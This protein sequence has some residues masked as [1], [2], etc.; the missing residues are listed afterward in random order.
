MSDTIDVNYQIEAADAS[1]HFV[2]SLEESESRFNEFKKFVHSQ[3]IENEDY[4]VIPG[5]GGKPTLIKPGAEKL[6]NLFGLAISYERTEYTSQPEFVEFAYRCDL[7]SRR[8]GALVASCEA[9]ACSAEK[10]NWAKEPLKNKNTIAKICQKRALVGAALHA[11]RASG[12]FTQDVEDMD[13]ANFQPSKNNKPLTCA[14]CAAIIEGYTSKAGKV[15]TPEDIV[16]FSMKDYGKPLC[17][18]CG[19]KAKAKGKAE[20]AESEEHAP[21][22]PAEDYAE[23]EVV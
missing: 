2:V 1:P 12:M 9:F 13:P 21:P 3:M 15:Y 11:T 6:T 16:K 22:T 8:T 10:A 20:K 17:K 4:G 5:T 7:T 14:E 23:A 19:F 18:A